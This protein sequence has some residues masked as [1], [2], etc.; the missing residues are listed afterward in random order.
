MIYNQSKPS[1]SSEV[2]LFSLPHSDT[3]LEHSLYTEYRP[4][5]S[6]EDS[7][8]KLEFRIQSN[9][10]QYLDLHDSFLYVRLKITNPDGTD[11]G[12]DAPVSACNNLL[13]SL[14]V[15]CETSLNNQLVASTNNCYAYK[16]YISSLLK[17]G[18]FNKTDQECS[19]FFIDTENF[20]SSD[21]NSGY[22][23]RRKLFA[24]SAEVELTGRLFLDIASQSR[25]ILN[26]T[27]MTITLT[28]S[29]DEFFLLCPNASASTPIK[30]KVKLLDAM[31]IIRKHT[32][33]AS[34]IFSHQKLLEEGK[35]AKY[36]YVNSSIKYFT[37]PKGVQSFLDEDVFT[38][39]IPSRLVVGMVLNKAFI[40]DL[41]CNPFK[42][43]HFDVSY[44]NV[45][46]NNH[47][48]P[49]R[50]LPF[51][52]TKDQVIHGYYL[53]N[54][55]MSK[56]NKEQGLMFPLKD[57]SKGFSFF[58]ADINPLDY[59]D[60]T[61]QLFKSGAVKIELKFRTPLS[62]AIT[63]IVYSEHQE[64]IEIDHQRIVEIQ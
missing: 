53:L 5:V 39:K 31:L 4:I 7:N 21:S 49:T 10:S 17:H 28:R 20:A 48:C 14:F 47:P 58:A 16:S 33:Y 46:V 42:F 6:V 55:C 51:D 64:M 13:H 11:L 57:Y 12:T 40:G 38:G 23:K 27:P 35:K 45:M 18:N 9:S 1:V 3:T 59:S 22:S 61:L 50:P 24:L 32:P 29:S 30:G 56:V 44:V 34:V 41:K 8:A 43:E 62:D 54:K 19:G 15:E 2:D 25:Y 26:D 36:P 63:L 60:D 37:I 52:F